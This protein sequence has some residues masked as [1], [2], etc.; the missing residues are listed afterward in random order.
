MVVESKNQFNGTEMR[1]AK[2]LG[3]IQIFRNSFP[4]FTANFERN[5]LLPYH[6]VAFERVPFWE[7][8][9]Q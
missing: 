2:I 8:N 1:N 6:S 7:F 9:M 4:P 3:V 5:F